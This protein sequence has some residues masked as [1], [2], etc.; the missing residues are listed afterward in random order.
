[1]SQYKEIP[2]W[3]KKILEKKNKRDRTKV[4]RNQHKKSLTNNNVDKIIKKLENIEVAKSP[5]KKKVEK[6]QL[7]KLIDHYEELIKINKNNKN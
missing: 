5:I 3:K 6:T 7:K 1:M 2:E 4:L